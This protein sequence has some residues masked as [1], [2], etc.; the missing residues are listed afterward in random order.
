MMLTK[1]QALEKNFVGEA[2]QI[3]TESLLGEIKKLAPANILVYLAFGN[4]VDTREIINHFVKSGKKVYL[5]TYDNKTKTYVFSR[6]NGW[7]KLETGPHGILQ[8]SL[9][10]RHPE[11]GPEPFV[12]NSFRDLDSGSSISGSIDVAII[13]GVA[14]DKK[15]VRLGY[16]K[17]VFDRLLVISKAYKIGLAYD[18]QIVDRITGE[19]HDLV[20]DKVVTESKVI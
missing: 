19:Q 4:E 16:G 20:M 15:R 14:F 13:P 10:S 7:D 9:S 18:F 2:S 3:I 12:P 5:P 1:R 17:G 11:P 6:F 8:P